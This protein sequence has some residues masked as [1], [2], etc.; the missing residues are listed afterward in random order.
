MLGFGLVGAVGTAAHYL[1]LII[2]VE[3]AGLPP[4]WATTLGFAVGAAVNYVLNHRFTFRS[5]KRHLDAGPKFFTIAL[6]TA[7]LNGWL[8]YIGVQ[9]LGLNYLLVQLVAT[10]AVFLAN[11]A[12]NS[13]WTFRESDAA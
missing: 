8:V 5:T 2:L 11:F 6:A 4:V 10:S 13:L 12:L 9:L 3:A 7:L 1:T